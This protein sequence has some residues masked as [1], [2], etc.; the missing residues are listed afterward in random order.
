MIGFLD[1][2]GKKRRHPPTVV[3]R[4]CSWNAAKVSFWRDRDLEQRPSTR[5]KCGEHSNRPL[6][7]LSSSA[8]PASQ[9]NAH[10]LQNHT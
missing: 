3:W 10:F 6:T 4:S 8:T 1:H 5:S 9:P 7:S 2:A